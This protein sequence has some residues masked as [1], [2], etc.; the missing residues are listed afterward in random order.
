MP[1]TYDRQLSEVQNAHRQLGSTL[2]AMQRARVDGQTGNLEGLS[3]DGA[4]Q[5]EALACKMRHL[6]YRSG[7]VSRREYLAGALPST[8]VRFSFTR[9]SALLILP[10]LLPDRRSAKS[11]EYLSG[12]V[13][14]ALAEASFVDT[15]PQFDRCVLCIV[16]CLAPRSGGRAAPDYD[17]IELKTVQDLLALY[18]LV[19]DSTRHPHAQ[20]LTPV[21]AI[22]HVPAWRLDPPPAADPT[23]PPP[24]RPKGKG[25]RK[26]KTA[27]LKDSKEEEEPL[28]IVDA[29][30][31]FL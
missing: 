2:I 25:S 19:D 10:P 3:L 15:L 26:A 23:P 17:N 29:R 4:H 7:Q 22:D 30:Q 11:R 5:A 20:L 28:R 13:Y 9:D 14:A 21:Y 27:T 12:L 31:L 8:E 6:I 24:G 1:T 18:L 16:H